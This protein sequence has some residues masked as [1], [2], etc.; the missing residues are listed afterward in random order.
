MGM[1]RFGIYRDIS[2][3]LHKNIFTL[4]AN[5]SII[6]F[7]KIALIRKTALKKIPTIDV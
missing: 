2:Q 6:F 5:L 1:G 3:L 7:N 4:Y